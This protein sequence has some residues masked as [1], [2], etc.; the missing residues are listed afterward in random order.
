MIRMLYAAG[1]TNLHSAGGD[2]IVRQATG[3]ISAETRSGDV[4]IVLSP[5]V[6]S[7]AVDA[8]SSQGSVTL[9]VSASLA[10][11]IDATLLTSDPEANGIRSDF[12]G[13]NIRRDQV[14]KK[15]RIRATG[16]VN[17]GGDRV[18]LYAEDGDITIRATG[19]QVSSPGL[20]P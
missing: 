4:T 1:A 2:I 11:D 8:K 15:T 6:R 5:Q 3:P 16:K 9:F 20:R 18:S 19:A 13:L 12:P 17:G 14:G 10:A 7:A